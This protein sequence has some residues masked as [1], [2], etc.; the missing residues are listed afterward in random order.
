MSKN[1]A[2]QKAIEAVE[3]EFSPPIS[4]PKSNPE[5]LLMNQLY[6]MTREALDKT[7]LLEFEATQ[8][9]ISVEKVCDEIGSRLF[10][11]RDELGIEE[12]EEE[13]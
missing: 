1:F 2:M 12:E 5:Y 7:R 13:G 3:K 11:L 6:Q 9:R 8:A 10:M 4:Y